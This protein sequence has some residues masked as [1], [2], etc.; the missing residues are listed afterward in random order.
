MDPRKDW[1][2]SLRVRFGALAVL[3]LMVVFWGWWIISLRVGLLDEA[4]SAIDSAY[5]LDQ[6][7]STLRAHWPED[8][9]ALVEAMMDEAEKQLFRDFDHVALWLK[10]H[11]ANASAL[12]LQAR[13]TL[14]EIGPTPQGLKGIGLVPLQLKIQA[15]Q[16]DD[17]PYKAFVKYF[18]LLDDEEIRMDVDSATVTGSGDGVDDIELLLNLW[19]R[20]AT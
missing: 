18:R 5:T 14:G 1:T 15:A 11:K 9:A 7:V 17:G 3:V 2:D 6:D 4:R 19:M 12:G 13:H 8:R 20:T 10:Q 16:Q